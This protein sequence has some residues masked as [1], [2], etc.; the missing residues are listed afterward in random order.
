[1]TATRTV[2]LHDI[3]LET[4]RERFDAALRA[5]GVDARGDAVE[6]VALDDALDRVTA[7]AVIARLSSPHYHA[8]AMDGIAVRA[9]RTAGARETAPVVL[10]ARDALVVDTGDPLP[11]GFDAVVP[12]ERVEPREGGRVAIRAAV[13]PFEHVRAIGED[14]VAS[15]VVVPA[16]RLLG[17][18]DLALCAAAGVARVDV[19]RRPRVALITT[20]DELVDVT[21][22]DPPPGAILDSNAVLLSACVK[23]YGGTV[24]LA[25]RLP[26]VEELLV[27]AVARASAS[28]DVVLVNAGSSAGRDD[29][30]ARVFAR[31]G[32]VVVHGVA[33]RPGHPLVLAVAREARVPLLGIPG[34]PVSAAICADLFLRPLLERLGRRDPP[35]EQTIDV[36]VTRKLYSPLGEDEYVRAVAARVDGR[37]VA[38]PLRRGA[39]VIT[40]LSRANVLLAIPRLSEG[41]RAGARL[42][43]R[44]LRPLSAIERTLLA[45]GS[46]DVAL[47]V[48]AG[49]LASAQIELVSAHVGS[50]A[51]LSALRQRAAHL[52]GTHVL[53]PPTQT[54]NDAAVRR[55]G[56]PEPVALVLLARREQGLVLA[57][58]NPLAIDAIAGIAATGARFVN[59]QPDAGTRILFDVLLARAGIAPEAIAGYDRIE[60]SHLAVAQLIANGSADAGLAIRAAA[61]AFDLPF[62]SVAW[63]PYELALP[64]RTL[65]EPRIAALIATLHDDAFR[66]EVESLGGYDCAHAGDVRIVAPQVPA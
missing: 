15:D 10:E 37:I 27:A 23:R 20:G 7:R 3:P 36:E 60:F 21:A 16:R 46:H 8:C 12:I 58:G 26:D 18:A 39:G 52:A 13:A 64:A 59:R 48:L 43:A 22:D 41:A 51:G 62:V 56:P 30:T 61:R 45:V 55:Y 42:P 28:A 19:V 47:D 49:R 32:D 35:D 44:A 50:I 38:T 1:M 66:R 24:A 9:A 40:S 14:V 6:T 31:F 11:P 57:R 53:D 5:H 25:I 17:P 4:A 63:E 65:E 34:Y 54:Y 2:F 33:I 29:Y